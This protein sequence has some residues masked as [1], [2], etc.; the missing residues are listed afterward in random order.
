MSTRITELTSVEVK[1]EQNTVK[2]Y[3]P[4]YWLVAKVPVSN[5]GV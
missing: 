1:V 4:E 2:V 5:Y 3:N